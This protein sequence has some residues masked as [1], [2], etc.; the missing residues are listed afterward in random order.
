MSGL[1]VLLRRELLEQWRTYRLLVVLA[2]FAVIGIVSPLTA[3]YINELLA[4]LGG[5]QIEIVFPTPTA[6]DAVAQLIKNAG[7]MG[8]FIAVLLTM[9]AV[10]TEKERG[11]AAMIL[12]KPATRPA[13]LGAKA[14]AV[15]LLLAAG[16]ALAYGLAAA[17]TAV[18]FEP[19][20][21]VGVVASALLLWLSLAVCGAVTFLAS[22]VAPSAIVAGGVGLAVV[23]GSGILGAFPA[24]APYMPPGLWGAAQ[25]LALGRA[26]AF[27]LAGPVLL[28]AGAALVALVLAGVAFRR[29]EL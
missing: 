18:L 20:P 22:T 19:L 8:A 6:A 12:T 13:F 17:Y 3:L 27:D 28:N 26:P 16:V 9:G 11:T 21:L 4:A 2:V 10:V 7:Q 23:L 24:L 14:L 29:Q 5:G 1:G 15:G 25:E